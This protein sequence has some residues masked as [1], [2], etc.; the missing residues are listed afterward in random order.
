M[1][2]IRTTLSVPLQAVSSGRAP[3]LDRL[4]GVP[5]ERQ[6]QEKRIVDGQYDEYQARLV[7]ID[8]DILRRE[9][10]LGSTQQIVRKL[11]Q[12]APIARQRVQDFKDLVD[13]AFISKHGY[14]EKEQL[15]IEQEGDLAT[16]RSRLK[17]L[18]AAIAEVHRGSAR[19]WSPKRGGWRSMPSTR[20]SRRP[21]PL[22]RNS[23]RRNRAAG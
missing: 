10:E 14:L 1:R 2:V 21:V 23:S 17:E 5:V 6:A 12:T 8:A 7:R 19:R 11:E 4:P 15:R 13:K 16:Q 3:V 20:R 22:A 18:A 9:A